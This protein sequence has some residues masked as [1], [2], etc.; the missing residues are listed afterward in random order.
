MPTI[1]TGAYGLGRTTSLPYDAAVAATQAALKE[2]GFGVL[3][4]IDVPA[5]LAAKIGVTDFGPYLILGACN[6]HLANRALRAEPDLGL[7]LPCN[8][9]VFTQG[10]GRTAVKAIDPA[11]MM[12]FTGNAALAP[13]AAEASAALMA[14]LG[15]LPA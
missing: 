15:K 7:L 10:D 4:E 11:K 9:V 6:P 8:V 12:G 2:V 3:W 14:A 13:I 5:T 1:A